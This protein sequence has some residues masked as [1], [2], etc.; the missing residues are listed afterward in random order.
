MASNSQ[1][2]FRRHET[3][4]AKKERKHQREI[5][6][7]FNKI[8]IPFVEFYELTGNYNIETID[9]K[10]LEDAL[11]FL[12]EDTAKAFFVADFRFI[13]QLGRKD[14]ATDLGALFTDRIALFFEMTGGSKIVSIT[15]T[16]RKGVNKIINDALQKGLSI[17]ETAKEIRKNYNQFSRVRS[18]AIA[19]TETVT[20]SNYGSVEGARATKLPVRKFWISAK[21]SR[22]RQTHLEADSRYTEENPIRLDEIFY[23]GSDQMQFAGS[24]GV[25]KENVNCRCTVGYVID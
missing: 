7:A 20:A 12:Y 22:T 3:K 13:S 21:D 25:A 1:K 11:K 10:P 18:K 24:G 16:I 19:R 8:I 15:E 9:Y 14:L 23:V 4:R 5:R 17:P 6:K 2:Q